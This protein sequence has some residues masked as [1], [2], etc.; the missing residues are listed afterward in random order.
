MLILLF[1]IF[2]SYKVDKII[3]RNCKN[4]S[5]GLKGSRDSQK[6]L[7]LKTPF[8]CANDFMDGVLD[9]NKIFD[10]ECKN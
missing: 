9:F 8:F 4:W 3:E 6:Y 10:T 7:K 5:L 2:C 1:L